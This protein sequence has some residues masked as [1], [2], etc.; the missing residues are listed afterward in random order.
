M[1]SRLTID[2]CYKINIIYQI[3]L[4]FHKTW[5]W[6]TYQCNI[7]E[8]GMCQRLL[9]T[10]TEG[11]LYI[12]KFDFVRE[13]GFKFLLLGLHSSHIGP[14]TKCCSIN[15]HHLGICIYQ[16]W[17]FPVFQLFPHFC[18][19]NS[20]TIELFFVRLAVSQNWW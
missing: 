12:V 17:E 8:H 1:L 3:I 18:M 19:K 5:Y 10:E 2:F 7:N 4:T 9:A 6:R 13:H 20:K 16:R 15:H 11:K 14:F